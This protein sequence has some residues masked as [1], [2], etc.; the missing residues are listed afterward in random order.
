MK[1]CKQLNSEKFLDWLFITLL[2]FIMITVILLAI[3][4]RDP[5]E[6]KCVFSHIE[7]EEYTECYGNLYYKECYPKTR[8]HKVCD[9]YKKIK[10]S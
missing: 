10:R 1:I 5:Y 4:D 7:I 3:F 6:Y 9:E 8:E 2:I